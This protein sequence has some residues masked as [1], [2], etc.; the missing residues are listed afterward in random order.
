MKILVEYLPTKHYVAVQ[1]G[2]IMPRTDVVKLYKRIYKQ[3]WAYHLHQWDLYNTV[4]QQT[5]GLA[6]VPPLANKA[7]E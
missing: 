5:A 3:N 2:S 7:R 1:K 6:T 4:Y